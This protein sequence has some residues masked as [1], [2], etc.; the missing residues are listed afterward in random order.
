M[1]NIRAYVSD[2]ISLTKPP[3]IS[4][5][6]VTATGAIFLASD[7]SPPLLITIYI[8]IGGTLGAAGASVINNVIDRNIDKAM[9]RTSKRAVPSR[10]ITPTSALVYGILLNVI[11]FIVCLSSFPIIFQLFFL[12]SYQ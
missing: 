8:L 7:G 3:I 10:R 12:F 4:L 5:L 11:S 2:L 1:N 9:I 6:L